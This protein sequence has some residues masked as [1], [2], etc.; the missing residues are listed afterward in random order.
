VKPL[1]RRLLR[2]SR[3][4]R[5]HLVVTVAL[6]FTA[7]LTIVAQAVLLARVIDRVFLDGAAVGDVRRELVGIVLL[8]LVRGLV[9]WGFEATGHHAAARA[10]S[11]LR[12][13]LLDRVLASPP[14]DLDGARTGEI[15]AA[16]VQ[17]VDALD[18]YFSRFLPQLVLAALVPLAV[19]A[20]VVHVDLVAAA[21]MV[22]T[23][24]L[25]PLFMVLIGK[26]AGRRTA[27]RWRSLS[28]LSGHFLDV[29]RGLPTLRAFNRAEAQADVIAAVGDRYR[30]ET[31]GTLRIAFLSA[32]VL[33]L[34]AMLATA[35]V[36]VVLGVR[37][38]DGGLAFESALAVLI[39]APELYL[40]LRRLGAEFHASA[41]GLAGASQ[42]FELL[43]AP[44]RTATGSQTLPDIRTPIR[45][46][47]VSFA[48]PARP[49][50]VLDRVELE[51]R[52]GELVVL[53]GP[54][55]AGKSTIASLLLC[56][57]E[58]DAGRITVGGV[59][60]RE[61]DPAAWREQVAWVPQRPHVFA[62]SIAENILLGAPGA[63]PTRVRAAAEAAGL[64]LLLDTR[65]GEGGRP[66][67]A[68]ETRRVALARAF[69]RDAPLAILDE[70]T[71]H[72]DA[73]SAAAV[74]DVV[75]RLAAGRTTL[76]IVP[77]PALARRA[78]RV[79][80]LEPEALAA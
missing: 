56:F 71:A 10:M 48:Y 37:L 74:A 23:L 68:G 69:L 6:G 44:L 12:G 79:V 80:M 57:D 50:L 58:P 39:L 61:L 40:P 63:S 46:E 51:L 27:A 7:A 18:A 67:S 21:I 20:W 45:F 54:N 78:D 13:R 4:A 59:D 55:G 1:D 73:H 72:L 2:S 16:A 35:M 26:M 28:L 34:A 60:L 31:M 52:R 17:G 38:A 30:R 19:L 3:A 29:A 42:I 76:L 11:E 8:A 62:G 49:S 75:E 33:E 66:L 36:A 5:R 9:S 24:P 14:R 77:A 15:A 47:Q 22:A 32:L 41:D 25:I 64:A 43:D 70:P 53:V 65:V